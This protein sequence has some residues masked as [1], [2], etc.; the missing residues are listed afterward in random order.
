MHLM[1]YLGEDGKR[2][3]TLK[4]WK[5]TVHAYDDITANII[6]ESWSFW[7]AHPICTPSS[8]F[9][10]W[11]ILQTANYIEKTIQFIANTNAGSVNP[12]VLI[13]SSCK[14]YSAC[15]VVCLLCFKFTWA[16]RAI[17]LHIKLVLVPPPFSRHQCTPSAFAFDSTYHGAK[18]AMCL[19]QAWIVCQP[20]LLLRSFQGTQHLKLHTIYR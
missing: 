7:K 5:F 6:I 13:L 20:S 16:T 11:S 17:S 18:A 12:K 19:V 10:W 9:A 14:M 8:I 4:V 2:V 15:A 3:Y 1:F